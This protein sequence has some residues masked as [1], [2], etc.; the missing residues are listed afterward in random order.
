MRLAIVWARYHNSVMEMQLDH[1]ALERAAKEEFGVTVD[2]G[3][4]IAAD[5]EVSR[6][7]RASVY[8]TKK[9][10]LFCMIH[11]QSNLTLG[12]IQKIVTRMGLKAELYMPPKGKPRYFDEIG[13]EKF[14]EVF[15]GRRPTIDQDIAYYRTLAPYNPA[16]VL[17]AEVREGVIY[18]YDS[19]S[20]G[21]WRP[22]VKFAYRRIKT[23]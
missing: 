21:G 22:C 23:S 9:K 2:V 19:D 4:V 8:L 7:A 10:Q 14:R 15:P 1:L 12:D 13:T 17:I 3:S 20:R 18:Q 6:T 5:V 16:L 11:A